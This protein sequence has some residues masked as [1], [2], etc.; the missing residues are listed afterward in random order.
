MHEQK[1]GFKVYIFK[2]M[3]RIRATCLGKF[4]GQMHISRSSLGNFFFF[5]DP[6]VF[7]LPLANFGGPMVFLI[8]SGGTLGKF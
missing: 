4:N 2:D 8:N 5:D 7:F 1:P 3:S 6:Y